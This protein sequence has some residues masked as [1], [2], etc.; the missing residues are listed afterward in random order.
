MFVCPSVEIPALIQVLS[1]DGAVWRLVEVPEGSCLY[2]VDDQD[3]SRL[4]KQWEGKKPAALLPTSEGILAIGDDWVAQVGPQGG[5]WIRGRLPVVAERACE[6][7]GELR[8]EGGGRSWAVID[9]L[10]MGPLAEVCSPDLAQA[11][12]APEP[13]G[14]R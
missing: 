6:V 8:V 7:N 1:E 12:R 4:V 14:T 5:Q 9:H 2:R 11:H 3:E 13:V 10:L